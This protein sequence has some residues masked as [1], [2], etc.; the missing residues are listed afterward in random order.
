MDARTRAAAREY[1][2]E[3]FPDGKCGQTTYNRNIRGGNVKVGIADRACIILEAVV[4]KD[5]PDLE[6]MC[7]IAYL[8]GAL[9]GMEPDNLWEAGFPDIVV[10][11]AAHVRGP[12]WDT[13]FHY[14]MNLMEG[15]D[16]Y[17]IVKGALHLA[18]LE[19]LMEGPAPWRAK[20]VAEVPNVRKLLLTVPEYGMRMITLLDGVT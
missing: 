11:G 17:K 16:T 10:M 6:V 4:G 7:Q 20:A 19:D 5:H 12:V 14:Y 1:R 8:E 3:V 2:L 18:E 13:H 15:F 9:A